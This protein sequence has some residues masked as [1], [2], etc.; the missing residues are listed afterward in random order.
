[1]S[2]TPAPGAL[3]AHPSDGGDGR[4]PAVTAAAGCGG[5]GPELARFGD[6][7]ALPA[8]L[9]GPVGHLPAL[10]QRL[11]SSSPESPQPWPAPT[12]GWL[13][14]PAQTRAPEE[15]V[16][17]VLPWLAARDLRAVLTVRGQGAGEI[18]DVLRIVRGSVDF[19]VVTAIEV[20]LTG[21]A[22]TDPQDCLKIMTRVSEELPRGVLRSA[23]VSVLR[24][25]LI[26]A[27]RHAVA[28]GA[29][30]LVLSGA[31]PADQPGRRLAGPAVGPV[32]A[33][34]LEAVRTAMAHGRI[35]R[36]PMIASGGVY[37]RA[38]AHLMRQRGASGVQLGTA[39]FARPELLWTL[40]GSAADEPLTPA[41]P[42]PADPSTQERR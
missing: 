11:G 29:G 19:G 20:D 23:K 24:P 2:H 31:V 38:S 10:G 15:V 12:G 18:A 3:T 33:G 8:V 22:G 26:A 4:I 42:D 41:Q 39:L 27:A 40:S 5:W 37:D 35:P 28:G 13:Y 21:S 32:T 16:A 7:G 34:G 30:V 36:L 9:V 14:Y 6:L 17:E 25:D 1:M